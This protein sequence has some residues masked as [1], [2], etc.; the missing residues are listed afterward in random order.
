MA[1]PAADAP[2]AAS[3][4]LSGAAAP[5]QQAIGRG[6]GHENV[7]AVLADDALRLALEQA[8][9][10]TDACFVDEPCVRRYLRSEK[11]D[12]KSA[13]KALLATLHWRQEVKPME[14]ECPSCLED[15]HSHNLRIVG[16]D[17]FGRPVL[18]TCF[19]QAINRFDADI[20]MVHLM[21]TLED[22]CR[23]LSTH[24]KPDNGHDAAETCVWVIDFH[25]YSMLYDSNPRSALL[26]SRMLAHYRERL[27]RL[28][29]LD[30]PNVFLHT[31]KAC[32]KILNE[33]TVAKVH[34]AFSTD[35]TLATEL[36]DW[37]DSELDHW[38][39]TEIEENR[40]ADFQNGEKAYWR[41]ERPAGFEA[42]DPRGT[43]SFVASPAFEFT[44]TSRI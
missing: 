6:D 22:A 40:H 43:P 29:L 37:A 8:G 19:N 9:D 5:C 44:W 36:K 24:K 41:A 27:G 35:G 23:I 1:S 33:V 39:T 26:A 13:A 34:F 10:E 15:P 11:G 38:L 3:A 30:A 4:G 25:G 28:V 7:L 21:R 17:R 12:I 42:H 18:Y 2:G 31:W 14:A 16:V 32:C 20:S